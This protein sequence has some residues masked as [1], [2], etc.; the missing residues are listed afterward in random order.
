MNSRYLILNA[1]DF[2]YSAG[3]NRAILRAHCQ[4]VLTSASLMVAEAGFDEAVSMARETPALGVGLHLVVTNDHALL[5]SQDVPLLVDANG[6]F[7]VE[8]FSVAMRYYF[9]KQAQGQLKCEM[10]AQ[11]ER[12]AQTGLAWSHVDGHQHFHM[13][14][15][16]WD[17]LLDL[18]DQYKV[19]RLRVPHEEVRAH[20]R[21]KYIGNNKNSK[22]DKDGNLNQSEPGNA[23]PDLNTAATLALRTLR[24]RNLRVLQARQAAIQRVGGKPFFLCDRVY[25]QM[26]TSDMNTAYTLALLDRLNARINEIYFHPGAP[27]A[28]RLPESQQSQG[29]YDVELQALL[30]PS[31]RARIEA[32][33]L[34]TGT[35]AEIEAALI[36]KAEK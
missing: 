16:V 35:Y 29:V 6:K 36:N 10:E 11:F 32:L 20:F 27:H 23:G 14:P 19:H 30:A 24:K 13:H 22:Y 12:F 1:D 3:V 31:V 7:G 2:G 33:E 4:G 18:C 9:S 34:T 25:G 17:N 15:V 26:Q 5:P 28:R 21:G 8:P